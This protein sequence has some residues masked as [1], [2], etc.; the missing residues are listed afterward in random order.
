MK[1]DEKESTKKNR[2]SGSWRGCKV[3]KRKCRM[4]N[5]NKIK[6]GGRREG[7]KEKKK[8]KVQRKT[9]SAEAGEDTKWRKGNAEG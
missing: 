2:K 8:E 7:K 5:E 9:S 6:R 3:E 1:E 4:V